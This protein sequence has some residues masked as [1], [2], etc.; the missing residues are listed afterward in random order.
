MNRKGLLIEFDVGGDIVN[1]YR[2]FCFYEMYRMIEYL[3][4]SGRIFCFIID[5]CKCKSYVEG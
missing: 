2:F 5:L 3:L 1:F 4:R